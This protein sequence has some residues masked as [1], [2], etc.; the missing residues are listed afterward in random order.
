MLSNLGAELVKMFCG[1]PLNEHL[2]I[3][4]L[5][6]LVAQA[7]KIFFY[8]WRFHKFNFR[9]FV[10]PGG[11]PSSHTAMVL[12]LAASIG[13]SDGWTANTFAIALVFSMIVIYDAAGVRRAAG[14]QATILNMIMEDLFTKKKINKPRLQELLGH[15]P[16]EVFFGGL[17]GIILAFA[18]HLLYNI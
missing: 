5:S 10:Q 11:M 7:L 4:L 6:M 13:F 3:A 14:N 17:L 8:Y 1:L 2:R 12:S 16:L 15:T 9:V 18:Y